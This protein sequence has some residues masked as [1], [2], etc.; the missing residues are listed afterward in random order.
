MWLM[1]FGIILGIDPVDVHALSRDK[2]DA[3]SPNEL[4]EEVVDPLAR[5]RLEAAVLQPAVRRRGAEEG[6][7]FTRTGSTS[8]EA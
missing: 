7:P 5:H 6:R 8:T 4:H 3:S 2:S 1:T